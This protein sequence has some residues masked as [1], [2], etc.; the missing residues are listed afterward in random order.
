LIKKHYL[1]SPGPTPVPEKVLACATLP[2]IH[3]RTDEFSQILMETCEGIQY[4]FQTENDVFILTSS[5]SGA[6]EAAVVNTL[7]P[8]D[9]VI[10]I[11]GGKFGDRWGKICRAYGI[12]T[13]EITLEWGDY[14]T[15]DVLARE[16]RIQSGT[17]AVF[18]TLAETSTGTVYDIQAYGS[19]VSDT[20]A[21]LVVDAISGIGATPCPMDDWKVDVLLSG[22]QKSFMTPP[23][24]AYI[25]FSPK[26]WACVETA[27][28][29]KFYFD[30]RAAK[31]SM[32]KRTTP[33]TPAI[34]L[35]IQ[36]R[37]ALRII[38]TIGLENLIRHHQTLGRA[39]RAGVQAIG[40]HL[41]S[42]RPGNILTAFKIPKGMDGN[43]LLKILQ[44]KYQI[45]VAGAQDPHKGEFIRIAHLGYMG[46]FDVMTAMSALEMALSETGYHF[47][48]GEAIRAA[49]EI[50]KE[51]WE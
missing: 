12:E 23:G 6:M 4:V 19:V 51:N 28:L 5:G 45:Q 47:K 49:Q 13:R 15:K 36:Q 27:S 34:S 40:L 10:S 16:M 25:S 48:K 29:P 3:H 24:L 26:A 35:V 41:L 42:R 31:K 14:L 33:W 18:A 22:S 8:G 7:S 50:L 37:E 43:G 32:A 1:L 2:I 9:K 46:G 44:K 30:A 21:I 39:T 38:R 11:N 20:D 17:K